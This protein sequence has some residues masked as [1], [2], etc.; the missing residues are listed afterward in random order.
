MTPGPTGPKRETEVPSPARGP[1]Q[2]YPHRCTSPP[3]QKTRQQPPCLHSPPTG[4]SR[5]SAGLWGFSPSAESGVLARP[6]GERTVSMGDTRALVEG[7]E[8]KLQKGWSCPGVQSPHDP[9]HPPAA[10]GGCREKEMPSYEATPRG[11]T[12]IPLSIWE[13]A[14]GGRC[15][16]TSS[17]PHHRASRMKKGGKSHQ[18]RP[19]LHLPAP[20]P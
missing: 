17:L 6:G 20:S 5:I 9:S 7:W 2:R 14:Q 19:R 1:F 13:R 3:P 4:C 18:D 10:M 12:P 15:P 8:V 11:R 16:G